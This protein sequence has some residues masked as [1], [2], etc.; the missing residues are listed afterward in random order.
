MVT[1]SEYERHLTT[2]SRA[3]V[4]VGKSV[5]ISGLWYIYTVSLCYIYGGL[6]FP[7]IMSQKTSFSPF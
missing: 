5:P 4:A 7:L 3:V 1:V 6:P 2:L